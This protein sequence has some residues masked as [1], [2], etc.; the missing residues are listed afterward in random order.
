MPPLRHLAIIMDGNGR[1]AEQRH[2]PRIVGHRRGVET[3]QR[4][5]A[6]CHA[7]GIPY[8]TLYAFSSENWGRP[9]EEVGAL[10]GLLG[11]YLQSELDTMLQRGVRLRVI[12]ETGRLPAD[13]QR[14][15]E[16]T[17]SRTAANG[18]MVLTLALSYGGRDEIVRG[19]RR[20]AEQVK[21]GA[22]LPEQIGES[23]L[24]AALDTAGIPDPDL[25]IRTSG[26]M[27]ISNFLLWQLAY[28]ELHFTDVLWPDFDE[29][30]L[31]TALDRFR[32]RQRRFGL[33]AAQLAEQA[34]TPGEDRH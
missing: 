8:L 20:L 25:L 13:V 12:G 31:Q 4:I 21:R 26:E 5:V 34:T 19:V 24:S 30:E 29:A 23:E 2:L 17:V 3:V 1:W 33:T 14:V 28:A 11:R 7:R 15:L 9:V 10:M 6:A 27:R 16:E 32:Q 18:E 22:L